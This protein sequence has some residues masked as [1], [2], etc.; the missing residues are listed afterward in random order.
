MKTG[1]L[2]LG[3]PMMAF[4]MAV[5]FAFATEKGSDTERDAPMTAYIYNDL[6]DCESVV[7][8]DCNTDG[9][10]PCTTS[11]GKQAF[12][13]QINQTTCSVQLFRN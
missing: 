13:Q 11:S 4:L 2:K 3:M 12:L 6:L 10:L 8:E 7:V 5:A 1:F 9:A